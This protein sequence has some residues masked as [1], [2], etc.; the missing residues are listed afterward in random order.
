M[1]QDSRATPKMVTTMLGCLDRMEIEQDRVGIITPFHMAESDPTPAQGGCEEVLTAMTSGNL[2]NLAVYRQT[3]P[4]LNDFF[5]DYVDDEYCLRLNASGYK[6]IR[7]ND[8]VLEHS[9]G[10]ITAHHYR[11]R[12]VYVANQ[13]PLRRYYMTRNRFCVIE[14]YRSHFPEYCKCQLVNLRGESRELFCLKTKRFA[15]S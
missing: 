15:N 2:L 7:C 6:V 9:P 1:D 5:I 10:N 8:A 13:N 12:T 11:G 14:K 4:F 3:G